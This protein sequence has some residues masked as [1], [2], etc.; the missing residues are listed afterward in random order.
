MEQSSGTVDTPLRE[1]RRYATLARNANA[2]SAD[3]YGRATDDAETFWGEAAR[4]L[5][6]MKPWDRVLEW[7]APWAK[8]FV[9]GEL[10]EESH[11]EPDGTWWRVYGG[12]I[13]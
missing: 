5:D 7:D 12:W 9:G 2:A 6:L 4:E 13:G 3:A 11:R 1:E 8:W 10:N